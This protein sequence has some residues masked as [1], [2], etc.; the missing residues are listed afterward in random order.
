[1]RAG[2]RRQMLSLSVMRI[3]PRW[4]NSNCPM[5]CQCGPESCC[6]SSAAMPNTLLLIASGSNSSCALS[7][8]INVS[9]F[10]SFLSFIL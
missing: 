3:Q 2:G 1:M 10:I 6:A 9:D 5:W 8:A 7:H 4:L